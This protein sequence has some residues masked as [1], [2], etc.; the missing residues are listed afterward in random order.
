[1]YSVA[2]NGYYHLHRGDTYQIWFVVCGVAGAF[3]AGW[4]CGKDAYGSLMDFAPWFLILS[5][6]ISSVVYW[7]LRSVGWSGVSGV[8]DENP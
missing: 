3:V 5:M 1:M 6:V 2:V 7:A 4:A 8:P